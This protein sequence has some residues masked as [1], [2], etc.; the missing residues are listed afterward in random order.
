MT[1]SGVRLLSAA[2]SLLACATGALAAESVGEL[3]IRGLEFYRHGNC[4]EAKPLFEKVLAR[5]PKN[6][7]IQKLLESCVAPK[8]SSARR[9][10]SPRGEDAK[11]SPSPSPRKV[12]RKTVAPPI[13]PPV[14]PAAGTATEREIAGARL[15]E[16]ERFIKEKNIDEAARILESLIEDKPELRIPRLRL[17]EI[18]SQKRRFSDAA[19]QY[20][21]LA[22]M[23]DAEPEARL[24]QAQN[25]A[26]AKKLK[27]S[28]SSYRQYLA[29]RPREAEA[30]LG[31]ANVLFWS[32]DLPGASEAYANYLDLNASD[33]EA[34]LNY[35]RALLWS[36]KYG[37][38]LGEFTRL[39]E[40]AKPGST[41][42]PSL[43]LA[44]AQCYEQLDQPE[45]ALALLEQ[46]AVQA[47]ENR[48][49]TA[50]RE[51][52]LPHVLL[53]NA[54]Q[55][56]EKG[57]YQGAIRAFAAYRENT[58]SADDALLQI[59]RLHG[60][61]NEMPDA[62]RA[63]RSYLEKKPDD[64]DARRELARIQIALPDFAGAR[65][66]YATIVGAGA[67]GADDYAGLV[68]A[69]I[70]EGHYDAAQPFLDRLMAIDPNH[71]AARNARRV[72][73]EKN[74][75]QELEGARVLAA[76]GKFSDALQ[77]YRIYS[78]NFGAD[79]EV[80]LAMARLLAWD[81]QTG[82]AVQAYHE[83]LHR[84]PGDDAVR[85]EMADLE[86][87]NGKGA[88]AS[89]EYREV[90]R[91]EPK[92]TQALFGLAQMADQR[93]DDRF[94]VYRAYRQVLAFEPE[95]RSARS[96]MGEIAPEISPSVEFRQSTFRDSDQFSRNV[97]TVEAGIPFR[98]GLRLSSLFKYGYFNQFREVGG[99]LCGS[100]A[101]SDVPQG[102][103]ERALSEEICSSRGNLK[104][105]GGG[106]G[107]EV[108]PNQS[109]LFRA[110]LSAM[111]MS[112]QA[113]NPAGWKLGGWNPMATAELVLR[114]GG[115]KRVV[116]A[117]RHRDA[118]YDVNT[119]SSLYAGVTGDTLE[120]SFEMPM[121][122][123]WNFWI[124]GGAARMSASRD[125]LFT[126]N[127]QRRITAR[128]NYN[129]TEW[130]TAG[131]YVRASNFRNFSPLYFSPEFYGTTGLSWTW[132]RTLAPGIRFLGDVE[133]G[134]GRINR[135]D[136]GGVNN[137]EMSIYPAIAWDVRPDLTLR[138]GYR[139]GRGRSSAF[140][141]PVYSTGMLDLGLGTYFTPATPR[142]NLNRIEIR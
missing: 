1:R 80:E 138:L 96:R 48:E 90:L 4:A 111:Q 82:K 28:A 5:Q 41:P 10:R 114:P 62:I 142:P 116:L 51:R 84:Y 21:R 50:G 33:N 85:L 139:F 135:Y 58:P 3:S 19:A 73:F 17:A 117:F 112:A 130:M 140:G 103:A 79:R 46:V 98:G 91:R 6:T 131:Y 99:R 132:D 120:A 127:L 15:Y 121:S 89:N 100:G 72:V 39:K 122:D 32:N 43:D 128:A 44:I 88:A 7:A 65:E 108:E 115:G 36:G 92:N 74:R 104:G 49:A 18:Y 123:R 23:E 118:I 47:P 66:S 129:V 57:D 34:R 137:L 54:Y 11:P 136:T 22:S 107:I 134:Y 126:N 53:R 38:A 124:S 13:A 78:Q 95:N 40:A 61:A 77:A 70:W 87:W 102:P 105:I 93:G 42:D 9:L 119:I 24:R 25:L 94:S 125:T 8:R 31:L 81:N 110:E 35:A 2:A 68:N 37:P 83:Y 101:S 133:V 52:L 76:T 59:A 30:R 64:H 97:S 55:L 29:L 63:Y 106:L 27:E 14:A 20:G 67:A 69:H 12:A 86:R 60:W 113:R 26:W 56:Q 71:E 75:V 109:I 141:S 45:R 16:A